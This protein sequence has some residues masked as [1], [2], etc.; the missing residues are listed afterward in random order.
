MMGPDKK[1]I[2][3]SIPI[4]FTFK[5]NNYNH[6]SGDVKLIPRG[7]LAVYYNRGIYLDGEGFLEVSNLVLH[8]TSTTQFWIRALSDGHLL[9]IENV[10]LKLE[11]NIIILEIL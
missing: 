2:E 1:C 6:T 7:D 5:R 10:L 4:T 3:S 8:H 9:D 11:Y